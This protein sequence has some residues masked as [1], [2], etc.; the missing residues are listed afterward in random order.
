MREAGGFKARGADPGLYTPPSAR[1]ENETAGSPVSGQRTG[2]FVE[3]S[4]DELA[5]WETA[6]AMTSRNLTVE[7]WARTLLNWRAAMDERRFTGEPPA[8]WRQWLA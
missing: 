3:C 6:V 4:A 7:E 5:A 1:H 8:W 2:L